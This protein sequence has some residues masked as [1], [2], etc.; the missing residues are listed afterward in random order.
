MM[1]EGHHEISRRRLLTSGAVG[2]G[3]LLLATAGLLTP[4][5]VARAGNIPN[6]TLYSFGP[7]D[8]GTPKKGGTLKLGMVTSGASETVDVR[9]VTVN[10]DIIRCSALY[11]GL[12]FVGPVGGSVVPGLATHWESNA[13]GDVW[14][15]TLRQ[16]VEWHNGKSL[17]AED[18]VYTVRKSWLAEEA[19]FSPVLSKLIDVANV[20]AS[21]PNTV[22]ITLKRPIAQF[23]TLCAVQNCYIVQ[24][25]F[26][27]W[28]NP[29]GTGAFKFSSFT[30]GQTSTFVANANYWRGAPH[31]DALIIDSSYAQDQTRFNAFR[32][33]DIDIMPLMPPV[34][35]RSAAASGS[36]HLGNQPGPGWM[37]PLFR[38]DVAPFKDVAVR[39]AV[40]L[41]L[42]RKA[43][44]RGVFAGYGVEGN[45]CCG[46]TDQY[47]A[48]SLKS[49][50]DPDQAKSILKKAGIGP[51]DL[52]ITTAA[53]TD[54]FNPMA[55]LFAHQARKAGINI[56]LN[57]L[58]PALYY[59]AAGGY[60]TRPMS[61]EIWTNAANSL[62]VFYLSFLVSGA[63]FTETYWG[64]ASSDK[65]IYDAIGEV[66]EKRAAE[67]WFKV[68]QLQ[69]EDG[70]VLNVINYNWLDGY[71][72]NVRGVK[73]T[74]AGSCDNFDFSKAWFEA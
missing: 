72:A 15:F 62:T 14:T 19:V 36:C 47:F 38:V 5:A 71:Q 49:T 59:T 42:D 12:C 55:T 6:P 29:I 51:L 13:R 45:D 7:P 16:G 4:P 27:D 48:D 50:Y 58:D 63:P 66:D 70:G 43:I 3:G 57:Q 60:Q 11:D 25:G 18:V 35:A 31:V 32:A 37:G 2:G 41:S 73:T 9:K 61:M 30:A 53:V 10:V 23:P 67:K 44:V 46:Y 20:K 26:T 56:K 8:G 28:N 22:V 33:M 21:G 69:H 1:S 39:K 17:T 68:Q 64:N 65:V 74:S 34:L 54:Q 40:K 24:D 52:E